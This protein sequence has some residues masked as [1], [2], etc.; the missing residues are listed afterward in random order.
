M[1]QAHTFKYQT[2]SDMKRKLYYFVRKSKITFTFRSK[3]IYVYYHWKL[4]RTILCIHCGKMQ[5]SY[6]I[7]KH[8]A[9]GEQT[10]FHFEKTE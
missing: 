2:H 9:K 7:R 3:R 6:C 4:G 1:K 5:L 10:T 8:L